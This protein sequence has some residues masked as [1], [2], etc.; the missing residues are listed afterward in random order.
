MDNSGLGE[1]GGLA[2]S[3]LFN[4]SLREERGFEDHDHHIP[5]LKIEK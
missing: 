1:G 4:V 5:S 3:G 2:V